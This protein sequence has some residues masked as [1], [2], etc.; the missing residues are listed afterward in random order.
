MTDPIISHSEAAS[1]AAGWGS[2][3]TAGDP[4][5]IFYSFPHSGAPDWEESDWTRAVAYCDTCILHAKEKIADPATYRTEDDPES[6][7]Y[8]DFDQDLADLED[9]RRYLVAQGGSNGQA[10]S[11]KDVMGEFR[12]M[13]DEPWGSTMN[14]W[15][16]FAEEI[17]FNRPKLTV[18]D[19]F[20]FRPSPMGMTSDPDD[21]M[22]E[23][24]ATATDDALMYAAN[25]MHRYAGCLKAAGKSY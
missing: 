5:A 1:I 21:Y 12:T 6:E 17:H 19:A 22:T 3:M 25:V 18:P 20:E 7:C 13:F 2:Y 24:A 11:R 15:F 16:A 23:I 14:A 9:L 8:E 4:G 10:L